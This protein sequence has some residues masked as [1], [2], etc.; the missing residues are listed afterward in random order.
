[1]SSL[2]GDV[3]GVIL[4]IEVRITIE[5]YELIRNSASPEEIPDRF[6][7]QKYDLLQAL[8]CMRPVSEKSHHCW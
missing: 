1:M 6:S 2:T 3:E 7:N 8:N 5:P 4:L